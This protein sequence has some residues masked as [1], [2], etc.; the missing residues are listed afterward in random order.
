MHLC[1]FFYE[2][3]RI[4]KLIIVTYS[5]QFLFMKKRLKRST[6]II[7]TAQMSGSIWVAFLNL[8]VKKI[9]NS[10]WGWIWTEG[11]LVLLAL[12][13]NH[14]NIQPT[15]PDTSATSKQHPDNH[16]ET[17]SIIMLRFG[18]APLNCSLE[19]V[20]KTHAIKCKDVYVPCSF[21][22]FLF[23]SYDLRLSGMLVLD[24]I[25][26][27][28]PVLLSGLCFS[29]RPIA[30]SQHEGRNKSFLWTKLLQALNRPPLL[31]DKRPAGLTEHWEPLCHPNK[32]RN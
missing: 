13:H 9:E 3:S 24:T 20:N 1:L 4:T 7:T 25:S 11:G 14:L 19:N 17:L 2:S 27:E 5:T 30:K 23:F 26:E 22:A 6:I 12:V 10:I 31:W 21:T 15:T 32:G 29:L 18:W 8:E 28:I 16:L